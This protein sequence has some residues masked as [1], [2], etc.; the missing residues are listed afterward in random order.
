[1]IQVA[2]HHLYPLKESD[3]Y[4]DET[5]VFQFHYHQTSERFYPSSIHDKEKYRLK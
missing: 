3:F 5:S 1:M 4:G 2:N